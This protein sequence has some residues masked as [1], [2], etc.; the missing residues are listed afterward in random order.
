MRQALEK[1]R[2]VWECENS[3]KYWRQ[4]FWVKQKYVILIRIE[5]L[6]VCV[7]EVCLWTFLGRRL[8]F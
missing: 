4:K 3:D 7:C 1:E 8:G 2:M 6:C 5:N